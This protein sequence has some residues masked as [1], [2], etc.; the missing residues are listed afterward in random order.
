VFLSSVGLGP[1]TWLRFVVWLIV[2]LGIY[3]C[4]GFRQSVP[5]G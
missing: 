1:F 3:F 2:G 5:N 4:Y